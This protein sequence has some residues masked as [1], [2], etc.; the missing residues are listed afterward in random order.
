MTSEKRQKQLKMLSQSI[1][2]KETASPR[3]VRAT[4]AV[5]SL[6]FLG[7]LSWAAF[8]NIH[9]IARTPGEIVPSGFQQAI[10]HLEG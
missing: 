4:M 2:L 9:E 7:F 1:R 10:Q 8:A 5:V 6:A 3:I